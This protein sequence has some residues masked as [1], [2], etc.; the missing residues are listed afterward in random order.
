MAA[1]ELRW[2]RTG[3]SVAAQAQGCAMDVPIQAILARPGSILGAILAVVE[4]GLLR[5]R[6]CRADR[7]G[8]PSCLPSLVAPAKSAAISLTSNPRCLLHHRLLPTRALRPPSP[9]HHN[10]LGTQVALDSVP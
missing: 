8:A 2:E 10:S 9:P 7:E 1:V 3:S 4:C 6:P 5:V